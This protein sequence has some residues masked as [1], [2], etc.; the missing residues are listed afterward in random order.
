MK[1]LKPW[2]IAAFA[3]ALTLSVIGAASA[4]GGPASLPLAFN[5]TITDPEGAVA[6]GLNVETYI[7]DREESCNNSS[8]MTYRRAG[9][10][11]TRYWV[12]VAHSSQL[13]GCGAE[14]AQVRFR[15]GDRYAA[16][17]GTWSSATAV[18]ALN[19][20][21]EPVA[22]EQRIATVHVAVWRNVANPAQLYLS[23]RPEGGAWTTH[24][25]DG[26]L[27]M[28]VF[29][30]GRFERSDDLIRVDV[31]LGSGSS[32]TVHVAVWRNVAN[33]AQLYLSTRPEG[34]AWT[35]HDDDGPLSMS[36]FGTGRFERSDDLIQVD[37]ELE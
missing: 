5:G 16:T 8:A 28:S 32:A 22:P 2:I 36:V 30:T 21:L 25:D 13:A 26:P 18:Q 15:I 3:A 9:E 14:G 11:V 6:A 29:G 12:T 33:P 34:G 35:T 10:S 37:I 7:G 23:T 20:T 27:S 24:D 31:D 17:T 4:Q 19:L 1:R